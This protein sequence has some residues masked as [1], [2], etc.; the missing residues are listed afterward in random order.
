M[1]S[2]AAAV[3]VATGLTKRLSRRVVLDAVD[4]QLARGESAILTG[5]NGAGKTTLLRVLAT[6]DAADEGALEI[7]GVDARADGAAAR[8]ALAHA[9]HEPGLYAA[10]TVRE[11]LR[12]FASFRGAE[13]EVPATIDSFALAPVADER[14]GTLSRG[15]RQRAALA[16][17]FL[18]DP[19][20]VL[21]DE[22]WTGLD[23]AGAAALERAIGDATARGAA[24]LAS[25]HEAERRTAKRRL[26]LARGKLTEVGG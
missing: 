16:R 23:A 5:A 15:T 14:A 25:A 13:S 3:L 10:L 11:N 18:G 22:P 4:V 17:A 2:R 26:V 7:G 19:A 21:L 24:V 12:F 8:R 9:G 20:L 1:A 6:L